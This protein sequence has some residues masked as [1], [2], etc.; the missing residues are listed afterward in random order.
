MESQRDAFDSFLAS[1]RFGGLSNRGGERMSTTDLGRFDVASAASARPPRAMRMRW[2]CCGCSLPR[3]RRCGSPWSCSASRSS[4][5][6]PARWLR[7]ITTCGTSSTRTSAPGLPGSSCEFSSPAIGASPRRCSFRSPAGKLLGVCLAVNL[8]G[9]ARRA[10]QGRGPR[11]AAVAR[12]G[13]DRRS[14]RRS[15]GR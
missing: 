13:D 5:C 7:S 3:W 12:L 8:V 1:I 11:P 4:S 10:V 2:T 9:G 6:W 15:P 14:A